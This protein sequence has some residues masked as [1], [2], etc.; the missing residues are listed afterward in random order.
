ML[1]LHTYLNIPPLLSLD[2]GLGKQK[3]LKELQ[4]SKAQVAGSIDIKVWLL[5]KRDKAVK[6]F[7]RITTRHAGN[8]K[9][10]KAGALLR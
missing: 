2:Q 5:G 8:S 1:Q 7:K 4:R 6:M 9:Y 10:V 3:T